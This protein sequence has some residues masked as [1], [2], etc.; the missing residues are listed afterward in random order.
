MIHSNAQRRLGWIATRQCTPGFRLYPMPEPSHHEQLSEAMRSRVQQFAADY[1]EAWRDDPDG[2]GEILLANFLPHSQDP[3]RVPVLHQLIPIDLAQRRKRGEKV[4]LESY[5]KD[6][7]EL[8]TAAQLPAELI[9]AE[10]TTGHATMRFRLEQFTSRHVLHRN[11]CLQQGAVRE[12]QVDRSTGQRAITK[13]VLVG[14]VGNDAAD[15]GDIICLVQLNQVRRR[16]RVVRLRFKDRCRHGAGLWR[17]YAGN[18]HRG[19]LSARHRPR[20]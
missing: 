2:S 6:Y 18:R 16:L 14:A 7:P 11:L 1:T 13:E 3:L 12:A 15:L 17:R 9:H 5:L 19:P 4:L 10:R 8:G 20:L